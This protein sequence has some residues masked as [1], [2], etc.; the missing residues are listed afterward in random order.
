MNDIPR[1]EYQTEL[2]MDGKIPWACS[3]GRELFKDGY[4]KHMLDGS[5][6]TKP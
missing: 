3:C 6:N 5:H 4:R 2:Y 1:N